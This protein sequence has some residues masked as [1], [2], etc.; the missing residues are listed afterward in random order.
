VSIDVPIGKQTTRVQV[1]VPQMVSW[2][3][4]ERFRWPADE[5]LLLSCGVVANPAGAA[6]PLAPLLSPIG[7]ATSRADALLL[8]EHR[9]TASDAGPS[10]GVAATSPAAGS[11]MAAPATASTPTPKKSTVMPASAISPFRR[12]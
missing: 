6:G 11:T 3:L 9:G 12:Y 5:V 10:G 4:N 8:V 7:G 2:R 1:Q